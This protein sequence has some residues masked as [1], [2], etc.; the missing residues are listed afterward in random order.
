MYPPDQPQWQPGMYRKKWLLAACLKRSY[1]ARVFQESC[2]SLKHSALAWKSSEREREKK[3]LWAQNS[4]ALCMCGRQI[5]ERFNPSLCRCGRFNCRPLAQIAI[6]GMRQLN[7]G[8]SSRFRIRLARMW[9]KTNRTKTAPM[10]ISKIGCW[11]TFWHSVW[12]SD[13]LDP[14]PLNPISL[15]VSHVSLPLGVFFPARFAEVWTCV[16]SNLWPF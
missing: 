16:S 3:L 2:L 12:H 6:C 5:C 15:R 11:L 4:D 8:S 1:A 10:D 7:C 9:V 13:R 14:S